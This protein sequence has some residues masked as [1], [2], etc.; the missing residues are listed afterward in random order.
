M[1][2][3]GLWG[4][5]DLAAIFDTEAELHLLRSKVPRLAASCRRDQA[6]ATTDLSHLERLTLLASLIILLHLEDNIFWEMYIQR[7][8]QHSNV[9][10]TTALQV[11]FSR[12]CSHTLLATLYHQTIQVCLYEV[13]KETMRSCREG[14]QLS[15][16]K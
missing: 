2:P 12:L 5:T 11:R 16:S 14:L 4:P 6:I 3:E 7:I 13:S 10:L 9:P 15:S 8:L 1:S